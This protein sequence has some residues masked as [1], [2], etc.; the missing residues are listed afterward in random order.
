MFRKSLHCGEAVIPISWQQARPLISLLNSWGQGCHSLVSFRWSYLTCMYSPA[1][2]QGFRNSWETIPPPF[3]SSLFSGPLPCRY[4][5]VQLPQT[6]VFAPQHSRT[7]MLSLGASLLSPILEIVPRQRG[8]GLGLSSWI[9]LLLEIM[10]LHCLLRSPW[11]T[12]SRILS[13]FMVSL[14]PLVSDWRESHITYF[15]WG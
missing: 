7:T 4:Q 14:G 3:C 10:V 11:K 12:F 15:V 1:L 8:V 13:T 6:L 9:P 2:S 5:L